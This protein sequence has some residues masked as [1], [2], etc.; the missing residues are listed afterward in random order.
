MSDVY[1]PDPWTEL[2]AHTDAR[3]ALGRS[4]A[5]L[6]TAEV[7]RFG[8]AHAQA[9]D[10]VHLPFDAATVSAQLAAHGFEPIGV[11]SAAA[12]RATYLHRPDLGRR[13]SARSRNLLGALA[14]SGCDLLC[15]VG[16]GLSSSAVHRHAV[17]LLLELRPRLESAGLQI[18]P[19]VL[20]HQARVALGDEIGELLQARAVLMLVGERPGLSSP[21]SLGAYL[22]WAPHVGCIDSERNCVSNI[23]PEGLAYDQAAA[24]LAW[25]VAAARQLGASG[26]RLKDETGP[27]AALLRSS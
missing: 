2:R 7:L 6:P 19:V 4:G 24:R 17:P 12:D 25:L 14:G 1:R 5:S 3:I 20:A 10:A 22:T 26:V 21:D 18:G 8:V 23:R 15:V 11:E 9:R 16:D 27:D 13:L